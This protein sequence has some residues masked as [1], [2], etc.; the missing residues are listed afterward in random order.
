M[1]VFVGVCNIDEAEFK[2]L[3]WKILFFNN[4]IQSELRIRG[5]KRGVD[6]TPKCTRP[7]CIIRPHFKKYCS[8]W[9]PYRQETVVPIHPWQR[10]SRTQSP[11]ERE[12]NPRP[13]WS[14]G[15]RW[16]SNSGSFSPGVNRNVHHRKNGFS[17]KRTLCAMWNFWARQSVQKSWPLADASKVLNHQS[18][19]YEKHTFQTKCKTPFVTTRLH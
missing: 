8:P 4:S 9:G 15:P 5:L 13:D 7:N 12:Q 16:W 11:R 3:N 10:W 2:W 6:K 18:A 19:R 17:V 1:F 14:Q